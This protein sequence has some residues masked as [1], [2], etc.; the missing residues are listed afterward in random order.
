MPILFV[1][2]L[3]GSIMLM[4]ASQGRSPLPRGHYLVLKM[5]VIVLLFAIYSSAIWSRRSNFCVQMNGVIQELQQREAGRA[6]AP[7]SIPAT[8]VSKK[9]T[10]ATRTASETTA[11]PATGPAPTVVVA[12]AVNSI[13]DLLEVMRESWNVQ[14]RDYVLSAIDSIRLPSRATIS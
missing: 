10:E 1:L 13:E 12:R 5:V 9:V 7:G 11:P 3:I 2:V 4:R 8:D 6:P 14:P